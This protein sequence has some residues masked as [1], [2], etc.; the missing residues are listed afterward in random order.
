MLAAVPCPTCKRMMETA[1]KVD[2][3]RLLVCTRCQSG[4][5]VDASVPAH[6]MRSEVVEQ[7]RKFHEVADRRN[8]GWKR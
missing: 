8:A 1:I 7:D 2:G 5:E 6:R 4:Y 3:D